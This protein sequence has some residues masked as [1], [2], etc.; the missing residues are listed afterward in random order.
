MP[1]VLAELVV[2]Q[3]TEQV[4]VMVQ[5]VGCA[6]HL[7]EVLAVV[8]SGSLLLGP[9]THNVQ[10]FL[11]QLHDFGQSLFE[12]HRALPSASRLPPSLPAGQS[13]NQRV[14]GQL[15]EREVDAVIRVDRPHEELAEAIAAEG[16]HD[17]IA[18]YL[19]GAPAEA[20]FA[21]PSRC[22]GMPGGSLLPDYQAIIVTS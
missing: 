18:H 3:P 21:A 4:R 13:L 11:A 22:G 16:P 17:L 10:L 19:W 1:P 20:V 9:L 2:V 8:S 7:V 5:P 12:I 14:L 6:A 15:T